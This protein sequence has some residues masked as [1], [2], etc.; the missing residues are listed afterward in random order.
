MKKSEVCSCSRG[1]NGRGPRSAS[2]R[3]E[4]RQCAVREAPEGSPLLEGNS[5][6][7]IAETWIG[8]KGVQPRLDVQ[9]G[10]IL[11]SLV[12]GPLQ[13]LERLFLFSQTRT[14]YRQVERRDAP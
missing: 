14:Q 5:C 6:E 8:P 7:Q 10:Q 1:T 3:S 2:A 4:K 12:V 9:V 13:P 11:V